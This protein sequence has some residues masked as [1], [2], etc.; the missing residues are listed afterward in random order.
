MTYHLFGA[1]NKSSSILICDLVFHENF[2]KICNCHQL[3]VR[4]MKV[5]DRKVWSQLDKIQCNTCRCTLLIHSSLQTQ[6]SIQFHVQWNVILS[7]LWIEYV[8]L[9][10]KYIDGFYFHYISISY[11]TCK[12]FTNHQ[13]CTPMTDNKYIRKEN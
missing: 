2:L 6:M 11:I 7:V 5:S 8:M 1:L 9:L 13:N 4:L 12:L 3:F 10:T